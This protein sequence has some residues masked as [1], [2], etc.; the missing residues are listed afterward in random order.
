MNP[1]HLN[2]A[3]QECTE[4][5]QQG[6]IEPTN[7]S[8]AYEAFYVNKRSEQARGKSRLVINYRPFNFFM[9]NDKFLLP[10]I[11]TL[12]SQ[13]YKAKVFSKFD[14]KSWLLAN[15]NSPWWPIQNCL[16]YTPSIISNGLWCHLG[17]KLPPL[18]CKKPWLKFFSLFSI[19][20]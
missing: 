10:N 18:C 14:L 12:F 3:I 9:K 13:L 6:L 8:C 4:L 1:K 15:R 16:L 11:N 5:Q 19:Q 20:F 7:S 2:L 17:S